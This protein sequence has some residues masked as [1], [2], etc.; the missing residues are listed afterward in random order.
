[1]LQQ[2]SLSTRQTLVLGVPALQT[3][4]LHAKSLVNTLH[5]RSIWS[6]N[7]STLPNPTAKVRRRRAIDK[8]LSLFRHEL[9]ILDGQRTCWY[10]HDTGIARSLVHT[11]HSVYAIAMP[12]YVIPGV[13]SWNVDHGF[14][15]AEVRMQVLSKFLA[16]PRCRTV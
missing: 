5:V 6:T 12:R 1:M 7:V 16:V 14:C 4:C 8:A 13:D 9:C 2:N 11:V 10:V 3:E 15:Q